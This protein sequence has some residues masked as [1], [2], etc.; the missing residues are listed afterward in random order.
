MLMSQ[1]L[2]LDKLVIFWNI[3][4]SLTVLM[5]SKALPQICLQEL[6]EFFLVY[7]YGL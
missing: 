5:K 6:V 1:T 3:N 2:L 7:E 4:I